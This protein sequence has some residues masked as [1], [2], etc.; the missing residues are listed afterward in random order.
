MESKLLFDGGKRE[1]HE[2]AKVGERVCRASGH[3]VLGDGS[4]DLA[5]NIVDVG[6]GEEV[7]GDSDSNDG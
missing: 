7:A 4:E 3:A 2:L 6:S 1:E 5:E